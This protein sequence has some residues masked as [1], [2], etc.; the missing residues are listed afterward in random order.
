MKPVKKKSGKVN[1]G[2]G[3]IR[4]R[5]ARQHNLKGV[6]IDLPLKQHHRDLR[7][8]RLGQVLPGL[9]HPLRRR[10]AA[11]RGDLLPLR[12]AVPRP[13]GPAGRAAY[14]RAFP[15]PSPSTEHRPG[16]EL[17]LNRGD[18][19]RAAPTTSSCSLPARPRLHCRYCGEPVHPDTPEIDP[20][21]CWTSARGRKA[22]VAMPLRVP[23]RLPAGDVRRALE[24]SGPAAGHGADRWWI[25]TGS[26]NSGGARSPRWCLT[27]WSRPAD[28]PRIAGSLEHGPRPGPRPGLVFLP[29]EERRIALLSRPATAPAAISPTDPPSPNLFSFN[30]PGGRLPDRARGSAGSSKSISSWSSPTRADHQPGAGETVD[31]RLLHRAPVRN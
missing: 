6:D 24:S 12:P 3:V 28:R 7:R 4:V 16:A 17:A 26:P 23:R 18:H 11:L 8:Q 13:H 19:D 15:R 25:S 2:R 1:K 30:C 10:P 9:R 14:R 20:E 21:A 29:D 5:G 22:V 31:H 27:V